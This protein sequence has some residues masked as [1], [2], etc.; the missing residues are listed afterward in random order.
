MRASCITQGTLFNTLHACMLSLESASLWFLTLAHQASLSMGILQARI[1]EWVAMPFSGILLTQGSNPGLLHCRW[2]PCLYPTQDSI[3]L[4]GKE[5]QKR[6]DIC[7]YIADSLCCT[8]ESNTTL[9]GNYTPRKNLKITVM[10]NGLSIQHITH[11]NIPLLLLLLLLLSGF[12][13]VQLCKTP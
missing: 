5:I 12:S 9:W 8:A 6:G 1:L 11:T 10:L 13:R 3:D 4:N 7:I 2:I